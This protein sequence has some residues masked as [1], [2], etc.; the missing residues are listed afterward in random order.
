[1][2]WSSM[3]QNRMQVKQAK[4]RNRKQYVF[5]VVLILVFAV[6]GAGGYWYYRISNYK[7]LLPGGVVFPGASDDH[8]Q[9]ILD[10]RQAFSKDI[11]NILLMGFDRNESRDEVYEVYRADTIMLASI[12]IETGKVDVISIPRDTLVPIYRRGGGKD[13][14]NSAFTYGW[15]YGGGSTD[16]EKYKLGMLYQV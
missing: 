11:I 10:I 16:E 1:M 15:R 2:G 6:V 13:K 5:I 7:K 14:I 12:N 3:A 4:K 9:D 8:D